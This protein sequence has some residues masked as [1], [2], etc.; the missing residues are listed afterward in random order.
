MNA[1]PEES[2]ISA[3][4]RSFLAREQRLLIGGKWVPALSG[5]LTEVIDPSSARVVAH[6]AEAD[7]ADVEVVAMG[8]DATQQAVLPTAKFTDRVL[9]EVRRRGWPGR[10]R[11][12]AHIRQQ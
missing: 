3:A 11:S 5:K 4:T 8:I 6:V 10:R 12:F 2:G 1:K 7:K 9:A